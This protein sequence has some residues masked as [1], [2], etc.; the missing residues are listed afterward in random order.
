VIQEQ[1]AL[2]IV[3]VFWKDEEEAMCQTILP[4]SR[5]SD[6]IMPR[7]VRLTPLQRDILWLLE[8]AG[9]DYIETM[10]ASI[11]PSVWPCGPS[12]VAPDR[13]AFDD[14]VSGLIRLGRIIKPEIPE[15]EPACLVLTKAGRIALET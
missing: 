9:Q 12:A 15:G 3:P 7:K 8:E 2:G 4:L 5:E 6:S 14:A 1:E 10:I 11:R 13:E